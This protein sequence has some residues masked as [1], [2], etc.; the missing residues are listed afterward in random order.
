MSRSMFLGGGGWLIG[1]GPR[2]GCIVRFQ[3][4][5]YGLMLNRRNWFDTGSKGII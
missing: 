1:L 5:G 4:K 2:I 3:I